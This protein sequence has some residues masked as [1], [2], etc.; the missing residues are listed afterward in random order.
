MIRW[1]KKRYN[2]VSVE[3]AGMSEGTST[4]SLLAGP[5]KD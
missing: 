5:R 1:H 4:E 2:N 3:A